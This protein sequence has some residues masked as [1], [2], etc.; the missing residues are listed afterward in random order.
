MESTS[1]S[2]GFE[3]DFTR[4]IREEFVS[5]ADVPLVSRNEATTVLIGKIYAIKTEPYSYS[6]EKSNVQGQ[7]TT[8]AL[9]NRRWLR[10]KLDARLVDRTTGKVIWEDRNMEEKQTFSVG[11]DPLANRYNQRQAVQ[12]IAQILAKRIYFKTMERF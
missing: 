8:Y 2:L 4:I 5:H 10:I 3:G 9:T 1:S 12:E 6:L 7:N 11:T